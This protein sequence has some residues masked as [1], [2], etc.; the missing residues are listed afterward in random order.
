MEGKHRAPLRKLFERGARI[1]RIERN[2][3]EV[4]WQSTPPRLNSRAS[5]PEFRNYIEDR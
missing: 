1:G 3:L 5:M 4:G 2:G